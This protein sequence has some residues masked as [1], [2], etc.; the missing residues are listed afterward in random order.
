MAGKGKILK[1]GLLA[2]LSLVPLSVYS[3]QLTVGIGS[4]INFGSSSSLSNSLTLVNNGEIDF[5]TGIH[6][7]ASF[8]N[9]ADAFGGSSTVILNKDWNNSGNFTAQTSTIEFSDFSPISLINGNTSFYN[10]QALTTAPK[11]LVF[12]GGSVQ[13]FLNDLTLTGDVTNLLTLTTDTIPQVVNFA[14]EATATHTIDF[15][16]VSYNHGIN[17]H[18]APGSATSFNS[19]QGL[20]VRGWFLTSLIQI[21]PTLNTGSTILLLLLLVVISRKFLIVKNHGETNE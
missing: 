16:N 11:S 3:S 12:E 18:I 1:L 19:V 13:T 4:Q 10:L 5:G 2:L 21:I 14:I 7:L 6:Q 9:N 17:Q 15:V 20:F 8:N